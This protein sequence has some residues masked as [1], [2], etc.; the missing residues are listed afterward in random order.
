MVNKNRGV[1]SAT[2]LIC[3]LRKKIFFFCKVGV[4]DVTDVTGYVSVYKYKT[5]VLRF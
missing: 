1:V 2:P 5:I 3:V 4:T